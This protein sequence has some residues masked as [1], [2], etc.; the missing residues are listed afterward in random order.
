[1]FNVPSFFGFSINSG[2]SFDPDYQAVL[3][4]AT[5]QSYTLPSASQQIL[6]NQLVLD[7]KAGGIWSKL[8]TFGVFATDGS[9]D[10]ALIDW[11]RLSQYTAVNSPTFTANQGF[12]GNGTSSY[13]DTNFNLL[14]NSLNYTDSNASRYMYLFSGTNANVDGIISSSA[15]NRLS[16]ISAS[17]HNI[18]SINN[19]NATFAYTTTQGLKSIHRTSSNDVSLYNAK[20]GG[21]RTQLYETPLRNANQIILRRG[22]VSYSDNLISMYAM[23]SSLVTE[24]DDFVDAFDNYI[25]SI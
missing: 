4:Y 20:I 2:V 18:N 11:I 17:S 10:F 13:I 22:S 1:M 7:L 16:I 3:N 5:S 14:N 12:Q 23:G 15:Y 19:L 21:T 25:T 24:N 6:Q 8:D 9:S